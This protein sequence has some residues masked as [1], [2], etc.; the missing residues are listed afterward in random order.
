MLFVLFPQPQKVVQEVSEEKQVR[1]MKP[2][3]LSQTC[4][5]DSKWIFNQRSSLIHPL[6]KCS[7]AVAVQYRKIYRKK[8]L[9]QLLINIKDRFMLNTHNKCHKVSR[10]WDLWAEPS[11]RTSVQWCVSIWLAFH[12]RWTRLCFSFVVLLFKW[13]GIVTVQHWRNEASVSV[14]QTFCAVLDIY[15]LTNA[16]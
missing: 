10:K 11:N 6:G 3:K 7:A 15:L 8:N 12:C 4:F 13:V 16:S 14:H 2:L 1:N 9:S 5:T